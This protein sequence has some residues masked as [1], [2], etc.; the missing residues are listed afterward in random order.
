MIRHAKFAFLAIGLLAIPLFASAQTRVAPAR[1]ARVPV[2]MARPNIVRPNASARTSTIAQP[3]IIRLPAAPAQ[4]TESSSPQTA[5]T[6]SI[7]VFPNG[8]NGFILPGAISSDLSQVMNNNGAPGFGFDFTHLAALNGNI[9]EKAFIDPVTQQDIALAV[10]LSQSTSGF[11][12]G[13]IPFWGGSGY[14]EPVEE[15][16]Q[17]Q[18]QQPQVI[19]LQQ[20]VPVTS[21]TSTSSPRV[22]PAPQQ[23]PLPDIGVFTLV[24]H[25]GNK[26]KAVAFTHQN[27]RIVYITKDGVR[28]SFAAADLDVSATEQL[29]QNHGTPLHLSL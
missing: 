11:F 28:D 16:P 6:P 7:A 15:E 5:S 17:P 21:S 26:V 18:Q 24:L 2:Q 27:D 25:N 23:P 3:R 1:P 9:G 22:E 8:T 12:G 14:S 13:F 29:N 19:V 10:Q 4:R 20:P